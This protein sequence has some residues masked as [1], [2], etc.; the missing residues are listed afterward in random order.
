MS[1]RERLKKTL[2]ERHST[3]L[4]RQ[5][6]IL[7]SPQGLQVDI[8]GKPYINFSS[9]DYLGLA[10]HPDVIRALCKGSETWGA[11]SGAAHLVTGHSRAHH[12]LEEELADFTGY[13]RVL[14][15]STGYMANLGVV[16]ALLKRG[17]TVYEDKLNHASL[18]D[19]G[20]LSRAKLRRYTH[21]DI[22]MLTELLEQDC[23]GENL[24]VTDGVFSMDGDIAPLPQMIKTAHEN[25]AWL[26]V[27]DAHGF[28]VLGKQ[29]RGV[30]EHYHLA[31]QDVDVLIGTLGKAFGTFGAFVAG[32]HDLIEYLVQQARSYIYTTAL[33]PAVATATSCSLRLLQKE[34][35]RREKLGELIKRFR[36]GAKQIGLPLMQS[37]T[38]IQPV[39]CHDSDAALKMSAALR[40]MGFL[41]SAIRPPTVPEGTARLRVTLSALHTEEHV[42]QLLDTFSMQYK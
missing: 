40:E 24:V 5:R 14:L 31:S 9:N 37:T 39:L 1:L 2:N 32:D 41:V 21:V 12:I 16:S 8:D 3:N 17:D 19:A 26:V 25:N 10:S 38:P 29:G 30:V 42:D 27:D 33:P 7:D 4:Y 35:W 23:K 6:Q 34:H 13:E 36:T 20:I 15:F 18:V 11:G 22:S 28:G